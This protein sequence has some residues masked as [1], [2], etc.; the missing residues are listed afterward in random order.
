MAAA[1]DSVAQCATSAGRGS[2]AARSTKS[3]AAVVT[4]Q[5]E[6]QPDVSQRE[7]ANM[8]DHAVMSWR[9]SP[10][11]HRDVNVVAPT[12]R[13]WHRQT[14]QPS[15]GLMA[16]DH[17]QLDQR[18]GRRGIGRLTRSCAPTRVHAMER[19]AVAL[20]P[21]LPRWNAR[22]VRGRRPERNS[23]Q[24][25]VGN[26]IRL[27]HRPTVR[28]I[29]R[30]PATRRARCAELSDLHS[31]ATPSPSTPESGV[32]MHEIGSWRPSDYQICA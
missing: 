23:L 5:S 29:T 26:W 7:G 13:S 4:R 10:R 24:Q 1:Q 20:A 31:T 19:R 3:R 14:Q 17:G 32:I 21:Q 9:G 28:R 22:L 30:R 6:V 12:W 2:V 25:M 16:E 27:R 15:H 11:Q 8:A 18:R